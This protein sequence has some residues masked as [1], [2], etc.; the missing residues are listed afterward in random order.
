MYVLCV[1]GCVRSLALICLDDYVYCYDERGEDI[2]CNDEKD[3]N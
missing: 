2:F 1:L 3:F